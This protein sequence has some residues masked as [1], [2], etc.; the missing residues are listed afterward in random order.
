MRRRD[1]KVFKDVSWSMFSVADRKY[2]AQWAKDEAKKFSQADLDVDARIAVT[3]LKG[4]DDDFNDDGGYRYG[5][6]C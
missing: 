4:Q 3:V 2:L 6:T 1:G 5:D